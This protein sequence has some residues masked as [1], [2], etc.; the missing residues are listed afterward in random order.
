MDESCRHYFQQMKTDIKDN[1]PYNSIYMKFKNG[2]K[3]KKKLMEIEVRI[4]VIYGGSNDSK[5][6]QRFLLLCWECCVFES[7]S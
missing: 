2:Q 1:V 5:S 3:K 6:E 4:A 7:G